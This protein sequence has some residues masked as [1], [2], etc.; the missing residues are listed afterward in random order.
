MMSSIS[1]EIDALKEKKK[2]VVEYLTV[3]IIFPKCRK[4]HPL[5]DFPLDKVEVC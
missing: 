1:L 2:Q 5:K 4:K 3:G